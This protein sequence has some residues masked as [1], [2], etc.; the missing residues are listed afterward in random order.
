MT[1]FPTKLLQYFNPTQRKYSCTTLW[2][3]KMQNCHKSCKLWQELCQ[4]FINFQQFSLLWREYLVY[5]LV[6]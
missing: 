4:L 1:K 5:G 6:F 3:T 2:N